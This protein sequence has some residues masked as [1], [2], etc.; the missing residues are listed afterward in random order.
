MVRS[1]FRGCLDGFMEGI[2][3]I[4]VV[5]IA[6]AVSR[7]CYCL[8]WGGWLGWSVQYF[9]LAGT[10]K[11]HL[12][13]CQH[14]AGLALAGGS[15]PCATEFT[16]ASCLKRWSSFSMPIWSLDCVEMIRGL[17]CCL[18]CVVAQCETFCMEKWSCDLPVEKP[19]AGQSPP[20]HFLLSRLDSWWGLG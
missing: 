15:G 1:A 7:C 20:A 16:A 8:S 6:L 19:Q 5:T 9:G 14:K 4:R 12:S 18:G 13:S 10:S 2:E 17:V 3:A 11:G